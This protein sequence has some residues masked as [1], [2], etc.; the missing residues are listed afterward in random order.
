M[1]NTDDFK[2]IG[3]AMNK[4]IADLIKHWTEIDAPAAQLEEVKKWKQEHPEYF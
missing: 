2:P 3:S 4:F 1:S